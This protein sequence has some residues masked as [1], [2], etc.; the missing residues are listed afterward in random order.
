MIWFTLRRPDNN[1]CRFNS[2]NGKRE[3]VE[4]QYISSWAPSF[5][6]N[7][8]FRMRV[9]S[10]SWSRLHILTFRNLTKLPMKLIRDPNTYHT[11]E[12]G[13]RRIRNVDYHF[14]AQKNVRINILELSKIPWLTDAWEK[15]QK[16]HENTC[17]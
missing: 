3:K 7:K 17:R 9:E 2:T 6:L 8:K 11:W 12:N 14:I 4:I 10:G 16:F 13:R 15:H 1:K 5:S